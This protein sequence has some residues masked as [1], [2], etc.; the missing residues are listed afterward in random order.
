MS[1]WVCLDASVALKLV[2]PEQDS[3]KATALGF[4]GWNRR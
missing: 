3:L 1:A 2:L 4:T